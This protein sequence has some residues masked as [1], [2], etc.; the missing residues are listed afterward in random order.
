MFDN[1]VVNIQAYQVADEG[2]Q[3]VHFVFVVK[4][5]SNFYT[6][7]YWVLFLN[8]IFEFWIYISYSHLNIECY[9]AQYLASVFDTSTHLDKICNM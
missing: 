7:N 5:N 8:I 6:D 4:L 9:E 2:V 1:G 3:V